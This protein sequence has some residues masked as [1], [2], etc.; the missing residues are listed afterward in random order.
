MGGC[1]ETLQIYVKKK[2]KLQTSQTW[3]ELAASVLLKSKF[4]LWYTVQ[5]MVVPKNNLPMLLVL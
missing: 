2:Y 5:C 4:F 3:L 1:R